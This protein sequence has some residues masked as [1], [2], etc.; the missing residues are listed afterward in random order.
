MVMLKHINISGKID[1]VEK[2]EINL[3]NLIEQY[4]QECSDTIKKGIYCAAYDLI[5]RCRYKS[6]LDKKVEMESRKISWFGR[7]RKLDKLQAVELENISLQM[8][9]IEITEPSSKDKYS[10]HDTLADLRVFSISEL[11]GQKTP[12]MINFESMVKRFFEVD[13]QIINDLAYRK[14]HAHPVVIES[15][16]KKEKTSHKISRLSERNIELKNNISKNNNWR[17]SN[18]S[19]E[20]RQTVNTQITK[21]FRT[22]EQTSSLQNDNKKD[23][24]TDNSM[25]L[26]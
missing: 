5:K 2:S 11:G 9:N 26:D 20:S 22:I 17:N 23:R 19:Y 7:L 3:N 24:Q 12:E 10:I 14:L 18:K 25:E 1:S 15:T 13:E 6:L 16:K 4:K 21:A 8:Q